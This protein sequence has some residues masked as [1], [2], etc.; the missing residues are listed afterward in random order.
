MHKRNQQF[1]ND[2]GGYR[3]AWLILIEAV[4]FN[5]MMLVGLRYS[6]WAGSLLFVPFFYI[7]S[8][9]ISKEPKVLFD[10]ARYQLDFEAAIHDNILK[11]PVYADYVTVIAKESSK[12]TSHRPII[13]SPKLRTLPRPTDLVSV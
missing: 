3:V 9:V 4:T 10:S 1:S 12:T 6:F 2:P 11:L 7:L 13:T 5:S 8:K